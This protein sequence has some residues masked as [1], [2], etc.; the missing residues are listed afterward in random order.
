[1]AQQKA[2]N[3]LRQRRLLAKDIIDFSNNDYLGLSHSTVL[4]DAMIQGCQQYGVG[5]GASPLVSGYSDAHKLL[6][7]ALCKQT[8]HQA[9]MIFNSGF[10]A[11]H[12]LMTTLFNQQDKVIADKLVHASIID[13]LRDSKVNFARFLHND[14]QSAEKLLQK[15]QPS[16]LI[17]E[18]VFSMDGDTAS[19]QELAALCHQYNAWLIVD[20]AHGFGCDYQQAKVNADIA[21]IQVVTFGKALGCQGAAILGSQ[22]LIDFL[23]ANSRH[24]IYSTALS[25]AAAFTAYHAVLASSNTII[26][27]QKL[28]AN[29]HL[30][31][32]YC[33]QQH[34]QITDSVT[35]IQPVIMKDPLQTL[36]VANLLQQQG[37][38]VGAIRPP[39]VARARLRITITSKHSASQ[40]MALIDKL[41]F[42]L[43]KTN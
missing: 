31:R 21:D 24:Y 38:L 1:M 35:A 14:L 13:G 26:S 41:A 18:S 16:A 33:Q 9:A 29:I 3:L 22:T 15:I 8:G 11:N 2:Q 19:L 40:I 30:F 5:S 34:I 42:A 4:I 36:A 37:F 23:V 25:P 6:E 7:Q 27:Q 43:K 10:S 12:A 39:T 28:Q 20:D 32:Q 17:T